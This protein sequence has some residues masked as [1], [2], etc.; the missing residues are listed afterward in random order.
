M[1][2]F[3]SIPEPIQQ[4]AETPH[5]FTPAHQQ[6]LGLLEVSGIEAPPSALPGHP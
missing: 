5:R 2:T 3:F 6:R 4:D 1:T